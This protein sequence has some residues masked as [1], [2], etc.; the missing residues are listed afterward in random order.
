MKRLTLLIGTTE[1]AATSQANTVKNALLEL[2]K[3]SAN[4]LKLDTENLTVD[5]PIPYELGDPSGLDEF[6]KGADGEMYTTG[7]VGEINSQRPDNKDKRQHE[8]YNKVLRK[9]VT[10]EG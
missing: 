10:H 3:K 1:S 7:L 4:V 9:L 5:S 2:R 8:E 6:G